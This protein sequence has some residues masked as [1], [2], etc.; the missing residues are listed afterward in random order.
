MGYDLQL[1]YDVQS[2]IAGGVLGF[3]CSAL[4]AILVHFLGSRRQVRQWKREEEQRILDWKREDLVRKYEELKK[5]EEM[6]VGTIEEKDAEIDRLAAEE[7]RLLAEN[8]Q[9]RESILDKL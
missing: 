1:S 8:K 3:A 2:F 5:E 7:Q 4:M 9:L 6:L